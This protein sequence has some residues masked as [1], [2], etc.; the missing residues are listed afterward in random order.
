MRSRYWRNLLN[1]TVALRAP[2]LFLLQLDEL[3]LTERCKDGS[4]VLFRDREVDV[5]DIET[6]EGNAVGLGWLALGVASLAVLL[7]FSELRNNGDTA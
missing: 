2:G 4:Q 5:S 7:C 1:K 6:V 3:Q